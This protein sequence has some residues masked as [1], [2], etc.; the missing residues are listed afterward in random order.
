M[1]QGYRHQQTCHFKQ[2]TANLECPSALCCFPSHPEQECYSRL[3]PFSFIAFKI[4]R[5]IVKS[6]KSV[7]KHK[8]PL[9][10]QSRFASK[11][12]PTNHAKSVSTVACRYIKTPSVTHLAL[13]SQNEVRCLLLDIKLVKGWKVSTFSALFFFRYKP[14][15]S[16]GNLSPSSATSRSTAPCALQYYQHRQG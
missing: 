13:L 2:I 1:R 3:P 7:V 11:N 4:Q 8:D 14:M 16:V 12:S 6:G 15:E 9:G 5:P 10:C